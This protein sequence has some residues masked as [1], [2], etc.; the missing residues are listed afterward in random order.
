M[1]KRTGGKAAGYVRRTLGLEEVLCQLAEEG[2]ELSHAALKLRRAMT[3]KN[4]TPVWED[5]AWENL[6]EELADV[7]L[8]ASLVMTRAPGYLVA[9]LDLIERQ[10]MARWWRRVRRVYGKERRKHEGTEKA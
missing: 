7:I 9:R 4:P 8:C 3:G 2:A 5:D 10:K 1:E 6:T